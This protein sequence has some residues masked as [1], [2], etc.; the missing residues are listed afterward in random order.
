MRCTTTTSALSKAKTAVLLALLLFPFVCHAQLLAPE[1]LMT[2]LLEHTECVYRN[3]LLSTIPLEEA[4]KHRDVQVAYI[5]SDRPKFGWQMR[6]KTENAVQSAYR[7]QVASTQELLAKDEADMWDSRK[8]P[9]GSNIAIAYEGKPLKPNTCYYWRVSVWDN[10]NNASPFSETK[11]FHTAKAFDT[12]LPRYPLIKEEEYPKSISRLDNGHFIDFGKATFGQLRMKLYSASANDTVFL[13]LGEAQK[14]GRVDRKPGASIRYCK[15]MI[16]LREGLHTYNLDIKSDGRNTDPR[17][18]ESGVQP[19]LMPE[20]IG[21]VY[22]FRYCEIE[23]YK[24]DIK[25][26][27]IIRSNVSYPFDEEAAMFCSSDTIINKVWDLCKHSIK[28]TTFCGVYVDGD[29]ERIPYEADAYIN[30]LSHYA[31]DMEFSMARYTVDYLMQW[32]TW[33]TEWIMQSILMLWNDYMHTGDSNLLQ[34]HYPALHA[35]T[36]SALSD[37]TGLISTRTGRQ[38]PE[39]L[40][41]IGFKGKAIRD[42]VDWPQSGALGIEKSEAGEADGYDLTTY[43]T[44]VN[45][46]HYRTLVLM[47]K[48]AK[49]LGETDDAEDYTLKAEKFKKTFNKAFFD[50]AKQCYRDGADSEHCS[51]H[52]NMFPLAFGLVQEKHKPSVCALIES[53]GMACSVYGSQFLMDALYNAGMDDHALSLLCSTGL[54]S[55][56][57]MI[58]TGSTITLEAWDT[59]FKPNLDWNHAWGAAPA[60]IIPRY[61]IGLQPIEPGFRRMRLKPQPSTLGSATAT[62]PTIQGD[63]KVSFSNKPGESFELHV[64]IPA[65]SEMEI[66]MPR[67]GKSSAIRINGKLVKTKKNGNHLTVTLGSGKYHLISAINSYAI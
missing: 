46:Y 33:P 49:V 32:P 12:T 28:A 50:K 34:R 25:E 18:N 5:Y 7:I 16:P 52:A 67:I 30:Q 35:R 27:D 22:P 65:N 9:S 38:T 60:N 10:N 58:R 36:L 3:G 19:I 62:I 57:N 20:Y 11:K 6:S 29:R 8:V 45:A 4:K 42:I 64:E 53:K 21:E 15:Y 63:V 44:V 59:R 31:T 47:A 61:I 24:Q 55:W 66:W 14:D 39:F 2:D 17:A 26:Q 23:N 51:L 41:S 48:I 1:R 54:R 40:K 43:N 37:S 56:Y 13:H